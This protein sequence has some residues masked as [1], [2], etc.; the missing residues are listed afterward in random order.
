MTFRK[1]DEPFTKRERGSF[2]LLSFFAAVVVVG[3]SES[4]SLSLIVVVVVVV[5]KSFPLNS[6]F[7]YFFLLNYL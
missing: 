1:K 6:C 5:V 4:F 3:K 7:N 2:L